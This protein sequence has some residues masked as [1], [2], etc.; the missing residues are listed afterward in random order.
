YDPLVN[1]QNNLERRNMVL[2]EMLRQGAITEEEY[3]EAYDSPLVLS[4]DDNTG[5]YTE[6]VHSYYIDA[7]IDDVI[8]DLMTE[9]GYTEKE[10]SLMLYSGG[11]HITTC[12]DPGIQSILEEVFVNEK[13]WPKTTGLKA[14]AAM[15]V[16]DQK[17]GNLLAIVGGRGEKK[18]S[19][20]LNRATHSK[21]QCGSSIKPIS[22]YAY[23]LETGLY[24]YAGPCDDI[25][26][27]YD[28][29][30]KTFWPNN[31]TN[32]YE[33]ATSLENAIQRSLNTVA[34]NTCSKL[35]VNRVFN[36]LMNSGFTS[37]VSS[38]TSSSGVTFSDQALSPLSLGSFTFGVSVRE[39]TQAYACLA[40]SGVTSRARTYTKVTD[41]MGNIVLEKGEEHNV[42]YSESTAYMIT[43]L[44]QTVVTGPYGTARRYCTFFNNY[45]GLE[46]AAKT[47]TTNDNKDLYFCGY[48][49][50]LVAACWYGY[51][52]NKT[53]T[54]ASSSC[55]E[56]WNT[57]FDMIYRHFEDEGIPYT[58]KFSVPGS[59]GYAE[60]TGLRIC[61]I[62]GKLAT[63]ACEHDI[64][65]VTGSADSCVT[66][67]FY[68]LKT[69]PPTEYCDKH[70]MVQWDTKT[71]AICMPGCS[72]P[73]SDLIWVGFR[74]KTKQERLFKGNVKIS[75]SQYIYIEV[76]EDYVYPSSKGVAFFRN[77]YSKEKDHQEYPG[78]TSG[79]DQP[80]NRI[81]L[82]HFS[83]PTDATP[84][85]NPPAETSK[86]EPSKPP[87]ESSA[88]EPP[89]ESSAQELPPESS[90][91]S[92]E[93]GNPTA[94]SETEEPDQPPQVSSEEPQNPA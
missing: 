18:L 11:L 48:T 70:V 90:S 15:C 45:D 30:E 43:R 46:I 77:L 47:G 32:R 60:N 25:P 50:D 74:L 4:D 39:M 67:N 34:V 19:R 13:Y 37:I 68:Y 64:A 87:E 84:Q 3:Y 85:V 56:L 58:K 69:E 57:A 41:S 66:S 36:N 24:N 2:R 71:K 23:A 59:V 83:G 49:P 17:T 35:G 29:D 92:D 73:E 76:P 86:D 75:D 53:I 51:D 63:D 6:F 82:E 42:L 55:G 88:P 78:Y 31:A 1:P 8:A 91:G 80:F 89:P 22:L 94:S 12:L 26:Y 16:M 27:S 7:V 79:A 5:T 9:Y 21:R 33:G 14:Q 54:S 72:C 10:A 38:F 81:C 28:K 61:T 62:S 44:L 20:G 65:Y 40:N 93:S 52:N